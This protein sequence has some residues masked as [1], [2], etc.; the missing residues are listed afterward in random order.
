MDD[1]GDFWKVVKLPGRGKGI[2]ATE[3]IPVCREGF[4]S[5]GVVLTNASKV[6]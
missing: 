4:G 6:L 1:R 2:V 5:Q 3:D